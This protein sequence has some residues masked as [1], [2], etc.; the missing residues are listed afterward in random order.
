MRVPFVDIC[1]VSGV[2]EGT[3][4]T[5][6]REMYPIKEHL[7]PPDVV[8][9]RSFLEGLSR[10][11]VWGRRPVMSSPHAGHIADICLYLVLLTA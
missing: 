3:V 4:R 1:D 5:S 8:S 9:Q 7:L 6:Y 2:A 10:A 11:F